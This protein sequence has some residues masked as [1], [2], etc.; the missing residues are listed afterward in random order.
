M[1]DFSPNDRKCGAPPPLEQR[2]RAEIVASRRYSGI[3]G[4][5]TAWPRLWPDRQGALPVVA[6]VNDTLA[7]RCW[8]GTGFPTDEYV[9]VW[10]ERIEA[11]HTGWSCLVIISEGTERKPKYDR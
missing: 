2:R 7:R 9:K 11:C 3:G 10:H 1:L 6:V 4:S 8:R 5:D